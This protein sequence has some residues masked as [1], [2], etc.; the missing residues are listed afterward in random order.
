MTADTPSKEKQIRNLLSLPVVRPVAVSMIF[1]AVVILGFVGINRMPVE[2]MPNIEGNVL[3]VTFTRQNS[4][5]ELVEREILIPLTARA[6]SLAGVTETS[7]QIRGSSGNLRVNFEPGTDLKMREYELS[8]IAAQLQREAER[9]T[10]R[11]DVHL[12]GGTQSFS[13]LVMS[14]RVVG[15]RPPNVLYNLAV[16]EIAPRLAAVP[17][18]AQAE[19]VGGG[20]RQVTITVNPMHAT[21]LGVTNSQIV[22]AIQRTMGQTTYVGNLESA[23]GLTHVKVDGTPGSIY[24]IKQT[25]LDPTSPIR[26]SNVADMT[27]GYGME[28]TLYRYNGKPAVNITLH[29]EQGANLLKVGRGL[30]KKVASLGPVLEGMGLELFVDSNQAKS[31]DDQLSRLFTL[32]LIGFGIALLVLY[33]FLRQWR[34]VAVVGIAV[35]VSVITA[36]ALLYLAGITINLLTIFGLAMAVGLL[37]DNSVVVYEAILRGVEHGLTPARAAAAGLKR[38]VRAIFAASLTTAIVF[39]PIVLIGIDDPTFRQVLVLVAISLT[40]PLFASLFVAIGLVPLLAYRLAAPGAVR[41]LASLRKQRSLRGG[42]VSPDRAKLLMSGLSASGL[43]RPAPWIAGAVV[44]VLFSLLVSIPNLSNSQLA[45]DPD[46]A[47]NLNVSIQLSDRN[48][49]NVSDLAIKVAPIEV[50]ILD[51]DSV[52][53]V[54]TLISPGSISFDIEFVE[55]EDRPSDFKVSQVREF[56]R[57]LARRGGLAEYGQFYGHGM[58]NYSYGSS[59]RSGL[60]GSPKKVVVSG[61]DSE[62]LIQLAR[63]VRTQLNSVNHI[64]FAAEAFERGNPEIWVEPKRAALDA[65]SLTVAETLPFLNFVS[66]QG[67]QLSTSYI[68]E[69]GREIPVVVER[70]GVRDYDRGITD[71]R[72]LQITTP[73]GVRPASELTSISYQR[74]PATIVH[75]NGRREVEVE[76][77]LSSDVPESGAERNQ[78]EASI[79][80]FIH[81]IPRPAG[82]VIDIPE[83]DSGASTAQKLILPVLALL[84]LVLALTFESLVL[85]FLVLLTLPLT[86]VGALWALVFTGTPLSAFAY[87]GFIVLAGLMVNPAILLVDR[88]QQLSRAGYTR[89]AAA[90]GAMKERTR[91]VLLTTATTIAALFPLAISTGRENELWPPF[92]VVVMGGLVS[93]AVLTLIVIPIG[94]V[95]LKR[96]DNAFGRLGPWLVVSWVVL[97]IGSVYPLI[98]FDLLQGILWQVICTILI[99]CTLFGLIFLIFRRVEHPLPD[100]SAGPPILEVSFLKKIYGLPGPIRKTL[101]AQ[102]QFVRAVVKASGK[103]YTTADTWQRNTVFLILAAGL[104]AIGYINEVYFWKLFFWLLGSACLA[105]ICIEIRK[106]RGFVSADGAHRRGGVEGIVAVLLPW[107]VVG[108]FIYFEIV[109]PQSLDE[110]SASWFWPIVA[111][112]LLLI[113]QGIRRNAVRQVS[114]ELE[115]RVTRGFTRYIRTWYRRLARR[116][117]GMDLPA[118]EIYALTSVSF[119]AKRGM[120]GILGPNGAGKTTLLRQLAGILEPSRGTIRIGG[121]PIQDIR[122]VLARWIGYLPQDA[123]LP[124]TLTPK[125]YLEYY[126]AL[127]DI[128]PEQRRDRVLSLLEEVGLKDKV[129]SKIKSLSG[130]MRQRV[131]VARTLLRLPPIIIVD[132]PTVGLD[133]R[134]RIRF[135]NLLSRLAESRIVLFSTHVV[136]DVAISCERVLV[137]AKSRLQFDGSPT[138]L[139]NA[140]QGKVWEFI[141]PDEAVVDL[142]DGAIV[143]EQSPTSEGQIL[144]RV[145]CSVQPTPSSTSSSP[146]PEDGYLWLLA[147]T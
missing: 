27:V 77:Q 110:A 2:L 54:Q 16:D 81:N 9:G 140:A 39:L 31:I 112:L 115:D 114:G 52:D 80:E 88:M 109:R 67:Q 90:L 122:E 105:K 36:L 60:G 91:P 32:G 37:V 96:L 15:E 142:P 119:K 25:R 123:G 63:E 1:L 74:P 120:I 86:V 126:A 30:E 125:E 66:D 13:S 89:G 21:S 40:L 58:G 116:I 146:R 131:A 144:Q 50:A 128:E 46:M 28:Q 134:E 147:T 130:G 106:L 136:E 64:A 135:R 79:K 14:V 99:A 12:F 33:L 117:G 76:Y 129:N 10:T 7:G 41:R 29:Q 53:A 132:E 47:D 71:L 6:S 72:D 62:K 94:Y 124:P 83:E 65:L 38:T 108:Y 102:K 20:T 57:D 59:Y 107:M 8:R 82:Y 55:I 101:N 48:Q 23:D 35:P 103:V 111:T 143:V 19:T 45:R 11:I 137:L 69:S 121:V 73:R 145:V 61:P 43:R 98:A 44:F 22:G 100:T 141:T 24:S 139:A 85:P 68:S 18:V 97:T 84:F 34:A 70:E 75:K 42:L 87:A 56:V 5:P 78:I 26:V 104:G 93:V 3:F 127:Y 133:P 118:N 49:D 17:G 4:T 92:A 51:M 113:G 138:E 95:L